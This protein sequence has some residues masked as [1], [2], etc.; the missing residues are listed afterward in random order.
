MF[1]DRHFKEGLRFN[2]EHKGLKTAFKNLRT[3]QRL[4]ENSRNM[5]EK[6]DYDGAIK[7]LDVA[8]NL[9]PNNHLKNKQFHFSKCKA[10]K[11]VW[12]VFMCRIG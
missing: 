10:L 12:F 5:I 7:E 11:L 6:R 4:E 8:L 1:C 9:D 2:P 3:I